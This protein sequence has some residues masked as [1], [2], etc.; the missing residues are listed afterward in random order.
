MRRLGIRKD[1]GSLLHLWVFAALC[2]EKPR[3]MGCCEPLVQW[4]LQGKIA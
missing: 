1:S 2:T 4:S 3:F